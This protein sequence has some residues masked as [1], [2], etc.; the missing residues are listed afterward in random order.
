MAVFT[1]VGDRGCGVDVRVAFGGCVLAAEPDAPVVEKH[2]EHLVA[3]GELVHAGHD[4]VQVGLDR[5]DL[6]G[7]TRSTL[8]EQDCE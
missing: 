7:V 6:R 1:L 3:G 8:V 5:G 2:H 4:C